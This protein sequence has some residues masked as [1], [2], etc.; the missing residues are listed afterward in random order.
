VGC[1]HKYPLKLENCRVYLQL[2]TVTECA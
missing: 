2:K 1:A